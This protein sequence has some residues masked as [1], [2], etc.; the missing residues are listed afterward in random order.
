MSRTVDAAV[1][2]VH[3]LID[4]LGGPGFMSKREWVDFLGGII[5]DCKMKKEDS[6]RELEA[7]EEG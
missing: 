6:E 3:E 2:Q 1:V 5:D 4:S 7:G